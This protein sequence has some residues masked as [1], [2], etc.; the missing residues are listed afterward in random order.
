MKIA[1]AVEPACLATLKIFVT[2]VSTKSN[3]WL[4]EEINYWLPQ[5]AIITYFIRGDFGLSSVFIN[6]AGVKS[7]NG[8]SFG[9]VKIGDGEYINAE[10]LS[11]SLEYGLCNVSINSP[12]CDSDEFEWG[13]IKLD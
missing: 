10:R 1:F 2:T 5:H 9:F 6:G 4:N 7:I 13:K 12:D 11:L 8:V 3:D